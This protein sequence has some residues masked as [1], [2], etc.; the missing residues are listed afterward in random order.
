MPGTHHLVAR[1][2][3]ATGPSEL[4]RV[5]WILIGSSMIIAG[6]IHHALSGVV[7]IAKEMLRPPPQGA[8]A[9]DRPAPA[10]LSIDERDGWIFI[11][12]LFFLTHAMAHARARAR[13]SVR[14]AMNPSHR[15]VGA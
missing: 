7:A 4:G 9:S 1:R 3:V 13:E 8:S 10:A 2:T 5:D 15:R 12:A 14:A 11:S 6:A